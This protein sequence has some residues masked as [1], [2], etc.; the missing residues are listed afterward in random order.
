MEKGLEA[1]GLGQRLDHASLVV[2]Y[3]F[4]GQSLL[5][6]ASSAEPR[7]ANKK[8]RCKPKRHPGMP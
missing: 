1:S 8:G 7:A 3:S 4:S 6:D 5:K 2:P